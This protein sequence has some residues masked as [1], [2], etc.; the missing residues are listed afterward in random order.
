MNKSMQKDYLL[1]VK[2]KLLFH[3]TCEDIA[4]ILEDLNQ[5]FLS[6]E[7]NGETEAEICSRLG[8]P[9]EFVE[10]LFQD[11]KDD[12][13]LSRAALC[14]LA[15]IGIAIGTGELSNVLIRFCCDIQVCRS[16]P[17]VFRL[18]F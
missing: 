2:N 18:C 12:R 1:Q 9:H 13:F 7:E 15:A 10:H 14:V 5:M 17:G 3:F 4:V 6:A 8:R 16:W 11:H